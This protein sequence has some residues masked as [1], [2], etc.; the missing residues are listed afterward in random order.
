MAAW[1]APIDPRSV[2][3]Q[4][5]ALTLHPGGEAAVNLDRS[6]DSGSFVMDVEYRVTDLPDPRQNQPTRPAG[7]A[8]PT[9][10]SISFQGI[11][12]QNAPTSV[13]L[14]EWT[15]PPVPTVTQNATVISVGNGSATHALPDLPL[16]A[17]THTMRIPLTD[18]PPSVDRVLL[19][20]QNTIKDIEI[21]RITIS[22][23][24]VHGD[25]RP[26]HPI[27]TAADSRLDLNGIPVVR[28]SNLI[29][30]LIPGVTLNLRRPS[31][32]PATLT[33]T[34]NTEA[35]KT[36]IIGFVGNYNQLLGEIDVLTHT[37]PSILESLTYMTDAERTSARELL[38]LFQ[39]DTMFMQL[40]NQPS[41][42]SQWRATRRAG[43][44]SCRFWP[45]GISTNSSRPGSSGGI[46]FSRLHGYL[47]INEPALD[48]ALTD[49]FELVK[50]LFGLDTN[51]DLVVDAGV[52]YEVDALARMYVERGGA[53]SGR[54]G[55]LDRRISEEQTQIVN[56]QT[57]LVQD[58]QDYRNRF[59]G[60]KFLYSV[61]IVGIGDVDISRWAYCD[62]M[63]TPEFPVVAI[64]VGTPF[65]GTPILKQSTRRTEFK[66]VA[67]A[68][69][70]TVCPM[71]RLR[72]RCQRS[73]RRCR[74]GATK[75]LTLH[76]VL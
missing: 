73:R 26:L 14:P 67:Q 21:V 33:V 17:G 43:R 48:S 6:I 2:V 38:G 71:G 24:S 51:G 16:D 7:P 41:G 75:P 5:Q 8:A 39:G 18:L 3:A 40:Q 60:V 56:Y 36:A 76:D 63:C 25:T 70:C 62:A 11:T 52:G 69:V 13:P 34:P 61:V 50:E 30:N 35:V 45:I 10:G 27:T 59:G 15:P 19:Q 47:E 72:R 74:E 12:I 68:V 37:D 32:D 31:A 49:K 29:D 9:P 28:P 1:H 53:F 23:P 65:R 64:S 4:D 20:N 66:D 57:K 42:R 58:E 44:I 22:D 46:D 55:T 54:I